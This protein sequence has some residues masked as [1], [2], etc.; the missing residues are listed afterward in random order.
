[1]TE[2]QA[3][4]YTTPEIRKHWETYGYMPDG[5]N[6]YSPGQMVWRWGEIMII[7]RIT[8]ESSQ[9]GQYR[10]KVYYRSSTF[11]HQDFIGLFQQDAMPL[12]LE[13]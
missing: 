10:G 9:C 11:Q 12:F 2:Q 3:L 6:E 8:A 13:W 4:Q 5:W 7:T 1:M